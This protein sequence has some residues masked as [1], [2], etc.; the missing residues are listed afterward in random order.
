MFEG[1][2]PKSTAGDKSI[3]KLSGLS[4]TMFNAILSMKNHGEGG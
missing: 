1:L 3:S 2:F 4:S